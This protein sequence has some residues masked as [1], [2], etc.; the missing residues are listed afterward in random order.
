[1]ETIKQITATKQNIEKA[2]QSI[3]NYSLSKGY[4]ITGDINIIIPDNIQFESKSKEKVLRKYLWKVT[5]FPTMDQSNRFLH[6]L[7]KKIL[8]FGESPKVQFSEKELAIKK[9]KVSWKKAKEESDRLLLEYKK[10]KG[11]FYKK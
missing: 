5:N 11:D 10:E 7:C 1:M 6:F 4:Q 3:K 9:A 8:K 2:I